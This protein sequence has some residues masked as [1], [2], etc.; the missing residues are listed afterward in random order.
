MIANYMVRSGESAID[1]VK[2]FAQHRPPGIYKPHYL[3]RLFEYNHE[4]KW[5]LICICWVFTC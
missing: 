4:R 3:D 5:A 2:I 1:A